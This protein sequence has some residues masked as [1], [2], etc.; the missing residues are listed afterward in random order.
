MIFSRRIGTSYLIYNDG[1]GADPADVASVFFA[2]FVLFSYDI[3]FV[4]GSN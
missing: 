3:N 4:D 1:S 2:L